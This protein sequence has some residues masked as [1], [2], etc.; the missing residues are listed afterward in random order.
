MGLLDTYLSGQYSGDKNKNEAIQQGLLSLG[1]GLLNS[2]GNFGNA[3]GQA[4]Q[5]GLATYHR[6]RE[7]NQQ[8][9]MRKQAMEQQQQM[10][11]DEARRRA[12]LQNMPSPQMQASQQA[13]AGGGG[14][15]MAN[16]AQMPQVDPYQQ[17]LH[18][19][20]T[21]GAA[22]F[23]SY[24]ASLQQDTSPIITK[25][26]DI[27]RDRRNPSKVVWQNPAEEKAESVPE[28][29]KLIRERD[30]L[31]PGHPMRAVYDQAIDKASKHAPAASM[32]VSYGAPVA[33]MD[34]NGNPVFIQPSKD[35]GPPAIMQGVTP[36][37]P[38]V[39]AST[40]EK[41]AENKVG[42]QKI[43]KALALVDKNPG[44]LGFQNN[45]PDALMQRADP[46]GVEVRAAV[47]DIGSLKI[48][49]RSGANVTVSEAPR[50]KPFIP[51]STDTPS[52]AKKKLNGL[53][54]ELV[55]MQAELE[56]GAGIKQTT[57]VRKPIKFGD[58]K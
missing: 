39:P 47:S 26:G 40:K 36:P 24:L 41:I 33:A 35:G 25:P 42:I 19:A 30:K 34:A 20:V 58:L 55:M 28:I 11:A 27:A 14:P 57:E 52:T 43:D 23:Q 15:T 38:P 3:L 9:E 2:K 12:F 56:A 46:S 5:Q 53:K 10:M 37:K 16:A 6:S 29:A 22:P 8:A 45:L 17:L 49:D 48:H 4:G 13:L 50:L 31:P 1:L 21:A 44:S 32:S 51:M 54:S 7:E 18:G